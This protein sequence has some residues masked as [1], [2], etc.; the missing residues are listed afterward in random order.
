MVLSNTRIPRAAR[1]QFD[2]KGFSLIEL[3]V[4]VAII[5]I[6]AMIALPQYQRFAAR[7]K[8]AAALSELIPGKAGLEILLIEEYP[9]RP[10]T[11]GDVGLPEHGSQCESFY[12]NSYELYCM[13][14]PDAVLGNPYLS[15]RRDVGT[16]AWSCHAD[17]PV[18]P[19]LPKE[20]RR[21]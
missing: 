19:F 13:M 18:E 6:L 17:V 20:C 16:G 14:K 8:V 15:L 3:M 5:S 1:R 7:A 12:V 11:P 4:V 2:Q 9:D 21:S 10:L